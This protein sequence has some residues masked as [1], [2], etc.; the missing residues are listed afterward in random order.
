MRTTGE[1]SANTRSPCGFTGPGD[2][3]REAGSLLVESIRGIDSTIGIIAR[4]GVVRYPD[5]L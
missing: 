1:G 2:A 4:I 3:G 5:S